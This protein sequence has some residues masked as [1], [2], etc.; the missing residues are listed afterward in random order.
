MGSLPLIRPF[1]AF[2]PDPRWAQ[3]IVAPPYD[4]VDR[5]EASAICRENP[6]SFLAISR[7][8]A[9]PEGDT[10]PFLLS[11]R[12]FEELVRGKRVLLEEQPYFYLYGITSGNRFQLGLVAEVSLKARRQGRIRAHEDTRPE[13]VRD[14]LEHLKI[15]KANSGPVYLFHRP[16][17]ELRAYLKRISEETPPLIE[18]RDREG[19]CHCL[20][21]VPLSRTQGVYEHF[22]A[23]S[24]LYIADGH[25]RSYSALLYWEEQERVLPPQA[26]ESHFLGVIFPAD[27]LLILGYH[28]F[29]TE[30]P[31][32]DPEPFLKRLQELPFLR[33]ERKERPYFPER[34]GEI[35][36]LTRLRNHV[37]FLP[38]HSRSSSHSLDCAQLQSLILEPELGIK[39]PR[40]DPRIHFFGGVHPQ[41]ELAK[42]LEQY[43]QG[44]AFTLAPPS[45]EELMEVVDQG[46]RM[47]PKSTWFHPKLLDG[48]IIQPFSPWL[49]RNLTPSLP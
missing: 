1:P 10:P 39:D 32:G 43:P 31:G 14:R 21:R 27:E 25:H 46:E 18:V 38:P 8:D 47:P 44:I 28:R 13:K 20:W 5:E 19:S 49:K 35:G 9:C 33:M 37:I 23:I 24:T 4:V 7:P 36:V 26:P 3:K 15:L 30:L 11:R 41:R 2:Y 12:R 34:K 45:L 22:Q 42:L 29:I 17:E 16:H 48:L 6:L 40:T